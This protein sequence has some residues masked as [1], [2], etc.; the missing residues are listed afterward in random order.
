MSDWGESEPS[1]SSGCF[2]F[3]FFWED[4]EAVWFCNVKYSWITE[5]Y[6]QKDVLLF[7]RKHHLIFFFPSSYMAKEGAKDS[8]KLPV[9]ACF[10]LLRSQTKMEQPA[11]SGRKHT[12][13][14]KK[15]AAISNCAYFVIN[16]I[17]WDWRENIRVEEMVP[18]NRQSWSSI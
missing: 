14:N 1:L 3:W 4:K 10:V 15:I 5:D 12:G 16:Y 13:Y 9:W 18:D 6:S 11:A 7:S 8:Q 2:S 17:C